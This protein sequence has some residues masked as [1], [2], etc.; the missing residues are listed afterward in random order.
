MS[1]LTG[2]TGL[3]PGYEKA[4]EQAGGPH[5]QVQIMLKKEDGSIA[6]DNQAYI[7]RNSEENLESDNTV[8][9]R[10]GP[11]KIPNNALGFIMFGL[12]Y[13][14]TGHNDVISYLKGFDPN[15]PPTGTAHGAVHCSEQLSPQ[16]F[17]FAVHLDGSLFKEGIE[18]RYHHLYSSIDFDLTEDEK[19][20][21]ILSIKSIKLTESLY[22]ITSIGE[23]YAEYLAQE[24]IK[25]D[26]S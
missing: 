16:F 21:N 13:E 22:K 24:F 1:S 7:F 17:T 12:Q 10:N 11:L 3:K 19:A 8:Y 5:L 23:K 25:S 2:I 26:L 6:P 4:I 15:E 20:K 9:P 18:S 14:F